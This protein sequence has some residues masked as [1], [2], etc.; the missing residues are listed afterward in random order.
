LSVVLLVVFCCGVVREQASAELH[1]QNQKKEYMRIRL[2][3][4]AIAYP[5]SGYFSSQ[6]ILLAEQ[7]I[8]KDETRLVK[9]VYNFLPYQPRCQNTEWST[10]QRMTLKPRAIPI[11]MRCWP[12]WG[13]RGQS[14]LNIQKTRRS[15]IHS[16]TIPPALLRNHAEDYD[17]PL[18]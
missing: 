8:E 1:W 11:A 16:P 5:R 17:A 7:Q 6:E 14:T 10:P 4:L 15:S 18:K 13:H 3:A 12:T 2:V 9:L